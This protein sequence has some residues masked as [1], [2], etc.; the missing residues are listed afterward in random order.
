MHR[1]LYAGRAYRLSFWRTAHGAEVDYVLETPDEIIPI[2]VKSTESPSEA[3]ARQVKLFLG[4]YPERARRG[5][6]VCRCSA[7]RR[8]TESV[9]AIP[10]SCL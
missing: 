3:D 8:L 6:V 4:T 7:P 1:C 10:W 2:E 5:Y 9:E